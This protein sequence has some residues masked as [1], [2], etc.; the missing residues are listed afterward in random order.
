[1]TDQMTAP[2]QS[3]PTCVCVYIGD[4]PYFVDRETIRE[5]EPGRYL[6]RAW[7][8]GKYEDLREVQHLGQLDK[9][10]RLAKQTSE[11]MQSEA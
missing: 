2:K 9:I 4:T 3:P 8:F 11:A 6:C 10:A 7:K 1:M 5:V